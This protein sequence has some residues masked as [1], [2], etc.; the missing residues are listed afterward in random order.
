MPFIMNPTNP[1]PPSAINFQP[2]SS[3][4]ALPAYSDSQILSEAQTLR[5]R[6]ADDAENDD[7]RVQYQ[8]KVLVEF[9][10]ALQEYMQQ[11]SGGQQSISTA[12]PE[13]LSL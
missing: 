4:D 5:G 3:E 7:F 6:L 10:D 1:P 8:V 11:T 12:I 2:S 13:Y 9:I